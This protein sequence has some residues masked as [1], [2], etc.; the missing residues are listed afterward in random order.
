MPPS[1]R[2]LILDAQDKLNARMDWSGLVK[3]RPAVETNQKVLLEIREPGSPWAA[4]KWYMVL[5]LDSE[6]LEVTS[7]EPKE[8]VAFKAW[9]SEEIAWGLILGKL[10]PFGTWLTYGESCGIEASNGIDFYHAE[11]LDLVW[12][13]IRQ[14]VMG[15]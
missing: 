6:R 13:D 1:L 10:N 5:D 11:Q 14:V 2:Q 7:R 3:K 12:R 9:L 4:G 8:G 15:E